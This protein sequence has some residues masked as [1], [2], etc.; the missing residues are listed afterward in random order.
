M[1][2]GRPLLFLLALAAAGCDREA[3]QPD[4]GAARL[5]A[6]GVP[7]HRAIGSLGGGFGWAQGIN[8]HGQVVGH[9]YNRVGATRAFV[10]S[11]A[12]G[13]RELPTLGGWTSWGYAI[14]DEG[15]VVGAADLPMYD[16]VR[17]FRWTEAG[18]M[19]NLGTLG[20]SSTATAVNS[21]GQITGYSTVGTTAY[22]HSFLW[23]PVTRVM[24]DIAPQHPLHVFAHGINDHG[25][26]AGTVYAEGTIRAFLWTPATGLIVLPTLGGRS[27]EGTD[28]SDDGQVVGWSETKDYKVHAFVWSQ[29][30]GI[31]DLGTLGGES[32]QARSIG[33]DGTVVGW[34]SRGDTMGVHAFAWTAAGGMKDLGA[35]AGM[36]SYAMAVNGKGMAAG[37]TTPPWDNRSATIFRFEA[38]AP[39]PPPPP[40][41]P[42]DSTCNPP[43]NAPPAPPGSPPPP[44]NPPGACNPPG[45]PPGTPPG[46]GGTP[47]N[48]QPSPVP[49]VTKPVTP[50]SL[51]TP[52]RPGGRA[53]TPAGGG[54]GT[55]K[56]APNRAPTAHAGGPYLLTE[57][58]AATLSGALSSD[59][60]GDPLSYDWTFGDGGR[61]SGRT[62]ARTFAR[63]GN[64]AAT[65]RVSD[66]RGGVAT[67]AVTARVLDVPPRAD[68]GQDAEV[69]LAQGF[70]LRASFAD[71]GADAWTCSV[72]W[73]DG[74]TTD[75]GACRPGEVLAASKTYAAPG[76][77]AVRVTVR[78]ASNGA[79]TSDEAEVT[80]TR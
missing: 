16:G 57:G 9:S 52:I 12:A 56:A 1:N 34:S 74:G 48:A 73:G 44:A 61:A 75:L 62:A 47:T 13:M 36:G 64:V 66:G 65:L 20:G 51:P 41:P 59:P 15:V 18:G 28:V 4:P 71:P 60:D 19:E 78:Q 43:G 40:P 14:N 23:D 27:A 63:L 69:T 70:R 22:N 38:A 2:R 26:V 8:E 17:A 5:A 37:W 77:Y 24:V 33:R 39:P 46:Q 11:E 72:S 25:H 30:G 67:A 45:N 50:R 76:N 53:P 55:P 32:S 10:W 79:S 58:S 6:G 80:V 49:P 68:A 29:A 35:P 31:R 54:R 3:L 42:P 21:R 7:T